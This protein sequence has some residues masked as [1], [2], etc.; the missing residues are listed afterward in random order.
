[1]NQATPSDRILTVPNALTFL[2][3]LIVP[4]FL[5]AGL[6]RE[7]MILTTALGATSTLTDLADGAIA[8]RWG[9]ITK[10]GMRLD[11]LSDR[12]SLAAG[13][14]VIIV[15][16]LAPLLVVLAIVGRDILLVAIGV[17]ILKATG[18]PI[19]EVTILGKRSSFGVSLGLGLFFLA[20]A[21]GSIEDPNQA[22]WWTGIGILGVSVPA[23][24]I[25]GV[26]Y[27]RRGIRGSASGQAG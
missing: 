3:L 16:S 13:I 10:L 21:V 24:L 5:W 11:P 17:P 2:R 22:L 26:D 12:L 25:A 19:P 18:R 27:L 14:V 23:Y 8:R 4:V 7:D 15:H 9:Q 20:A 1:V 6:V